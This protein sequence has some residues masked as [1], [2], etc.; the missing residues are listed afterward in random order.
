MID[1]DVASISAWADSYEADGLS[2]YELE[3][4]GVGGMSEGQR[5]LHE[6]K[7]QRRLLIAG[8]QVGKTRALAAETWWLALGRHPA[9]EVYPAPNVGWVMCAD[10]KAGWANFSSKL[11]EIEPPGVL[12]PGVVYD[13]SLIHI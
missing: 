7:H 10:L 2:Q 11:R 4:P 12:E 3:A 1:V 13:L 8:N 6:S 5:I 9:R